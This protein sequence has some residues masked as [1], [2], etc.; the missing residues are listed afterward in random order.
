[1]LYKFIESTFLFCF[2]FVSEKLTEYTDH[3][4]WHVRVVILKLHRF[5]C[6]LRKFVQIC[7]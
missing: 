7:K 5:K 1:M 3:K 2:L 6:A 4:L